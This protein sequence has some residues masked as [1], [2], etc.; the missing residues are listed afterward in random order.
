M[1]TAME[2]AT[3]VA[4]VVAKHCTDVVMSP[5]SR[6][7]PL[8]Y[9]LLARRDITVH[10]RIDERS[11]AFTARRGAGT[12]GR[13]LLL[14]AIHRLAELHRRLRQRVGLGG[15]HFRV[16]ALESFLQIGE[17]VLDRGALGIGDLRAVLGQRGGRSGDGV[18][19]LPDV[20]RVDR[21][22]AGVGDLLAVE[23]QRPGGLVVRPQQLGRGPDVGRTEP[24][25]G[26]VAHPGVERHA[27]HGDVG[28]ADL[29]QTG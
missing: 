2:L 27:D 8:A 29:I 11:A 5:G 15:D 26:A 7:S 4:G 6:N 14:L 17:R 10:M 1:A 24:G 23:R 12:A 19:R 22:V 20:E 21:D 16:G 25:A 13:G 3:A 9:A 18:Q 28:L